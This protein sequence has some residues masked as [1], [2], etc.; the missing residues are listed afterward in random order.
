[1]K[2]PALV[3][4]LLLS[5]ASIASPQGIAINREPDR[6]SPEYVDLRNRIMA[7]DVRVNNSLAI[8]MLARSFRGGDNGAAIS[9]VLSDHRAGVSAAAHFPA[10]RSSWTYGGGIDGSLGASPLAETIA[11]IGGEV[12][13]GF[14]V[15]FIS[16]SGTLIPVSGRIERQTGISYFLGDDTLTTRACGSLRGEGNIAPG[17]LAKA[18]LGL[19][20]QT[21]YEYEPS[22][23]TPLG[24]YEARFQTELAYIE[25]VGGE[26]VDLV[27]DQIYLLATSECGFTT[28]NPQDCGHFAAN[29]AAVRSTSLAIDLPTSLR[30]EDEI[31][32]APIDEPT[33]NLVINALDANGERV[34]NLERQIGRSLDQFERLTLLLSTEAPLSPEEAARVQVARLIHGNR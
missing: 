14:D 4:A 8:H 29:L 11:G 28:P 34:G 24:A 9:A 16:R 17:R 3:I 21:C 5:T 15:E 19:S 30:S 23:F 7:A 1:M 27:V 20:G 25:K 26:D 10:G 32:A 6:D 2:L 31:R 22:N 13:I 33:A 18:G 12:G